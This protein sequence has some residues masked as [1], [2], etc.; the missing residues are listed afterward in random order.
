VDAAPAASEL[1]APGGPA[2]KRVRTQCEPD[3]NATG[4]APEEGGPASGGGAPARD[5]LT[6]YGAAPDGRVGQAEAMP[7]PSTQGQ[8]EAASANR[9]GGRGHRGLSGR[10]GSGREETADSG[11]GGRRW[12][13]DGMGVEPSSN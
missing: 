12:G 5:P 3:V 9:V 7:A 6:R 11:R 1:G 2:A 10:G 4:A 13:P 8:A